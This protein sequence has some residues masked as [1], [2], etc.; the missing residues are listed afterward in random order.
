[1][2]LPL[3][4]GV[5]Q[6]LAKVVNYGNKHEFYFAA[7]E[8]QYDTMP[9]GVE[10]ALA[11]R[12]T[13]RTDAERLALLYHFRQNNVPEW[14]A[15]KAAFD[16]V[17]VER[18]AAEEAMPTT[19]VM[20]EMATPRETF[21]LARGEYDQPGAKVEPGVPAAL[22][23]L[24]EGVP[25]NR[26]GLAKWLVS[27]ENPLTSRV[28]VNRFWQQFFGTGLVKTAEDFGLQGEA[29]SHPELLDW[30]AVDFVE[31][32]WDVKRFVKLL[33]TSA[34]YRQE[35]RVR[36]ELFERDPENRLVARGPRF[37]MDAEMVRDNALSIAGLLVEKVGGPSVKPYQPV[38]LWEESAYG[39]DFTAQTFVQDKGDSL[40]RRTMYTFWKRQVPPP[41][42]LLFDAPNRE[43]C[44]VRRAR[45]NTPLQALMLMNDPQFVEASRFFAERI[46][47]ESGAS[48]EERIQY[49][50]LL[51]LG[52]PARQEETDIVK[53]IFFNQLSRFET[54]PGGVE[55]LLK[56]G[57]KPANAEVPAAEL[58]AWTTVAS[59][60]LNL[61][62][63]IT[64]L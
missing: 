30:L 16:A 8:E 4:E 13:Q 26:L 14:Q 33:V 64:K 44:A 42:M 49:G 63:A 61:D 10:T 22:P 19:M 28:T 31:S 43:T 40:Y 48:V 5:N 59:A 12:P 7:V 15:S 46:L 51:S 50:F 62:E 27:A 23:P 29:P 39:G 35:S 56:V 34:A 21:I 17:T 47:K 9:A 52:R 6:V 36:P 3:H 37:R 20:A 54:D 24:P 53:D 1:V 41:G 55:A 58:A 25:N 11:R 60:L 45:T 38:G 2:S 57:E 18:K 32:G